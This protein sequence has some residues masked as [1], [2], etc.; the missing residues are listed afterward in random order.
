MGRFRRAH[1]YLHS[2]LCHVLVLSGTE[3]EVLLETSRLP[4]YR[5]WLRWEA[6]LQFSAG[7]L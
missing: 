5:W 4:A 1:A 6:F 7:A 3:V 2:G